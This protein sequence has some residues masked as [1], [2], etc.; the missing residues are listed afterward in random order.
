MK[1]ANL[2]LPRYFS[3]N[4]LHLQSL[5]PTMCSWN[6]RFQCKKLK[7]PIYTGQE[8]VS[9]HSVRILIGSHVDVS[10]HSSILHNDKEGGPSGLNMF[11]VLVWNGPRL[12]PLLTRP[13]RVWLVPHDLTQPH[14]VAVICP[15]TEMDWKWG[16]LGKC[17]MGLSIFNP[18]DRSKLGVLCRM[19]I[20]C[21]M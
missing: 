5:W 15:H 13:E 11:F 4:N 2:I 21:Q 18:V 12:D 1:N 3:H 6:N 9:R 20:I 16:S 19:I 10:P 14:M 7:E 8:M 17:R